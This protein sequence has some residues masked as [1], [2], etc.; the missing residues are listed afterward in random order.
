MWLRFKYVGLTLGFYWNSGMLSGHYS[1]YN[2]NFMSFTIS[3]RSFND[4][5]DYKLRLLD[6]LDYL[7][8]YRS[9]KIYFL[10]HVVYIWE[11]KYWFYPQV[12]AISLSF[13]KYLKYFVSKW[14]SCDKESFARFD[15]SP[16][17]KHPMFSLKTLNLASIREDE[18]F[19]F[20]DNI[21]SIASKKSD[22]PRLRK[23]CFDDQLKT[24]NEVYSRP[25]F[26]NDGIR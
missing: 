20:Y 5:F 16:T 21:S 6:W 22:P 10:D 3:W 12:S 17:L 15:P 4:K 24:T 25:S 18:S 19:Y 7:K 23:V 26:N 1:W 2:S 8:G 13:R 9:K 11:Q 14:I